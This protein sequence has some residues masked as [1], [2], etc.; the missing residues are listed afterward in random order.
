[1]LSKKLG[2]HTDLLL[3]SFICHEPAG[4]SSWRGVIVLAHYALGVFPAMTTGNKLVGF[5][6]CFDGSTLLWMIIISALVIN[7]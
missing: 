1:M 7:C 6:P 4:A 5:S 3:Q 2:L